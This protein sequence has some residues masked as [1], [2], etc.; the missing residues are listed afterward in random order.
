MIVALLLGH[1]CY[2]K[3]QVKAQVVGHVHCTTGWFGSE[4]TSQPT[5]PRPPATG[6]A[7]PQ[8]GTPRAHPT[9]IAS[10]D[11]GGHQALRRVIRNRKPTRDQ[12]PRGA[13]P[14]LHTQG[15]SVTRLGAPEP[16][17]CRPAPPW[18][19]GR[20]GARSAPPPGGPWRRGW[21][22]GGPSAAPR[23]RR[24]RAGSGSASC[25]GESEGRAGAAGP[26][27][28]AE[29][30][31]ACVP[32]AE[33]GAAAPRSREP[34]PVRAARLRAEARRFLAASSSGIRRRR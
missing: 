13:S 1:I 34:R 26:G 22:Q 25:G 10:S 2:R 12:R 6:R 27:R 17:H 4:G 16:S 11:G 3:A 18:S 28:R 5:Q 23:R 20:C 19:W 30:V 7:A 21:E 24:R 14:P 8:L 9:P 31:R 29:G 33:P 32:G 15:S